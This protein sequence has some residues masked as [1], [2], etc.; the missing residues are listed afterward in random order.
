[1]FFVNSTVPYLF[2]LPAIALLWGVIRKNATTIAVALIPVI[3]FLGLYGARFQPRPTQDTAGAISVMTYNM[4]AFNDDTGALR[5][6][7][8]AEDLDVLLLQELGRGIQPITPKDLQETLPYSVINPT[9]NLYGMGIFSR[10]PV[11]SIAAP[12]LAPFSQHTQVATLEHPTGDVLIVNI[13]NI[14][15]S[16]TGP[17][18]AEKTRAEM[19]DRQAV[20]EAVTRLVKRMDMPTIVAGDFNSTEFSSTHQMYETTFIDTWEAK[21]FGFGHTFPGGPVRPTVLGIRSPEWYVRI[22]YIFITPD[23]TVTESRLGYWDGM[24]DH[25][26]V[27]AVIRLPEQE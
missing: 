21:G 19:V 22:D 12:E 27:V 15:V 20:A 16:L 18:L 9:H 10:Y 14:S 25:R 2:V 5:D 1:M 24:S 17:S 6:L 13:H 8:I 4:N 3:I 26:P 7:S 23:I 11:T